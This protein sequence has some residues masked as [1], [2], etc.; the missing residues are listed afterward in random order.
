MELA[1]IFHSLNRKIPHTRESMRDITWLCLCLIPGAR[2]Q[3]V[4]QGGCVA[5]V[6]A[7]ILVAV[8]AFQVDA[9]GIAGLHIIWF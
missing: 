9:S 5:D 3:V 4:D 8:D 6:D 2:Q 7:A 1:V